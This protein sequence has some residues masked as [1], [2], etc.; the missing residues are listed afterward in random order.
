MP[1]SIKVAI[2]S[3]VRLQFRRAVKPSL[4]LLGALSFSGG[5]SHF[6]SSSR[7]TPR[8]PGCRKNKR[9]DPGVSHVE[10]AR[11]HRQS[12]GWCIIPTVAAS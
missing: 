6:N 11:C 1:S 8:F 2:T 3:A 10:G 12:V 4:S 7:W 9:S 5:H